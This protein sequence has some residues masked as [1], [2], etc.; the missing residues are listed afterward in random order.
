MNTKPARLT[1]N[2]SPEAC[3]GKAGKDPD[4]S[5]EGQDV[6][7]NDDPAL[8]LL[9]NKPGESPG[10]GEPDGDDLKTEKL[11]YIHQMLGELRKLSLTLD[12]PMIA[13]LIEMALLETDTALN[14]GW[15]RDEL[16]GRVEPGL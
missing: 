10:G 14:V 7:V 4:S 11:T 3:E 1:I 12:E 8:D 15:F 13:Y 5:F 9:A 16:T 6:F 2:P